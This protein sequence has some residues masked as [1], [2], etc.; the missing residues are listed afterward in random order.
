MTKQIFQK[1]PILPLSALAFY[2]SVVILWKLG[3]IP[4]PSEILVFLENL[5]AL[6]GLA[7]LFVAS[8][9]EGVVYLGLYFPGSFIVALAVILSDGGL[10]SL[11]QISLVV[12]TALTITSIIN[13]ILGSLVSSGGIH[14]GSSDRRS[15]VFSKGLLVSA[16]HPNALAFYFFHL[17]LKKQSFYKIFLVPVIMIPYGFVLSCLIYTLKGT[18]HTAIESPYIMV[19]VILFWIIIAFLFESRKK[20]SPHNLHS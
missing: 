3:Y 12:A 19:L 18:L 9:L 1:I 20:R 11:L 4:S 16:L 8:A 15:S 5:Y 13:Y 10:F 14:N 17:G 2:L 7:G 6:H